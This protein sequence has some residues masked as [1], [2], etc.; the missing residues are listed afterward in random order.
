MSGFTTLAAMGAV[1]LIAAVIV[2]AA[3]RQSSR[4]GAAEADEDAK[5][6]QLN[7]LKAERE[8]ADEIERKA[9]LARHAHVGD[10][11]LAKRLRDSGRGR[12]P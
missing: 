6:R 8:R 3:V 9:D 1:V 12:K 10:K 5:D 11:P 2:W 7:A 4:A